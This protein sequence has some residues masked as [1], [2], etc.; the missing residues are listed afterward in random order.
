MNR[1]KIMHAF[2]DSRC[3][4][5][6]LYGELK[7]KGLTNY[8]GSPAKSLSNF[9]DGPGRQP[10]NNS[11]KRIPTRSDSSYPTASTTCRHLRPVAGCSIFPDLPAIVIYPNRRTAADL[12]SG[13]T[14]TNRF[15]CFLV[16]PVAIARRR[17]R[18][19]QADPEPFGK[20]PFPTARGTAPGTSG[21]PDGHRR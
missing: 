8:S 16:C 12:R 11:G 5:D 13:S 6:D 9:E 17:E 21:S 1:Q 4:N 10:R 15:P 3:H 7:R 20:T 2:K 18:E 19:E 14:E